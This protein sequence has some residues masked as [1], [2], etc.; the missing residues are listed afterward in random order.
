MPRYVHCNRGTVLTPAILKFSTLLITPRRSES[1]FR[2][3]EPIVHPK[4]HMEAQSGIHRDGCVKEY[5]DSMPRVQE[6]RSTRYG[7]VVFD[8]QIVG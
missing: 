5:G 7:R 8:V 6:T 4:R 1:L 3:R 2:I